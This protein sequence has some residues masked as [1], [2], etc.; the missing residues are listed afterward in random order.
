M[1][2][3]LLV[4]IKRVVLRVGVTFFLLLLRRRS[5]CLIRRHICGTCPSYQDDGVHFKTCEE[6]KHKFLTQSSVPQLMVTTVEEAF[7]AGPKETKMSLSRSKEGVLNRNQSSVG[8]LFH[9]SARLK[10]STFMP[11]NAKRHFYFTKNFV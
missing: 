7:R 6:G 1:Q 2:D 3:I 8:T 9:S 10:S 4:V 5:Y 11:T